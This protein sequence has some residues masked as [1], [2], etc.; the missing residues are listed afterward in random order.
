MAASG[1]DPSRFPDDAILTTTYTA[2]E[3]RALSTAVAEA[4]AAAADVDPTTS[5]FQLHDWLDPD[6]LDHLFAH[7]QRTG[8]EWLI[9][10]M[11]DDYTVTVHSDGRIAVR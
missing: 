3:G 4:I 1:H 6:A 5:A 8:N 10:V 7:Q 11:I 9:E 2:S